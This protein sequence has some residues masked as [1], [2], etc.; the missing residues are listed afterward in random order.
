MQDLA[1]EDTVHDAIAIFLAIDSAGWVAIGLFVASL[2]VSLLGWFVHRRED[3]RDK[4]DEKMAVYDR[5]FQ[6]IADICGLDL[7]VDE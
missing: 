1:G 7:D 5:K 6:R 4:V 2:V 3:W